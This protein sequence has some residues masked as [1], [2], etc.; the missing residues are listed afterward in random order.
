MISPRLS[1]RDRKMALI[2]PEAFCARKR[3]QQ[4]D[5][6]GRDYKSPSPLHQTD[7]VPLH[8]YCP[9]VNL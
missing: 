6:D 9:S 7:H 5:E 8:Q 1:G 3:K 4:W 2:A